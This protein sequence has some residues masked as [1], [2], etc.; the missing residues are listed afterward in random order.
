MQGRADI[1]LDDTG[2][3]QAHLAVAEFADAG[4]GAIVSSPLARARETAQILADGIGIELGEADDDFMEQSFGD[5]DGMLVDVARERW[6]ERDF[7]GGETIPDVGARGVRALERVAERYADTDIII[8]AHGNLIRSTLA[9]ASGRSFFDIALLPNCSSSQISF[10]R[11]SW[12]VLTVAGEP[13]DG[14]VAPA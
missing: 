8:V 4:W 12:R 7:P 3:E 14:A 6:P 10:E 11:G 5:V 1:P 9:A 2:R 13:I